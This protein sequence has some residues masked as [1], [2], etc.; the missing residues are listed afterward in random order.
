MSHK[1]TLC[2]LVLAATVS[3]CAT[4][5]QF[6]DQMQPAAMDTV[7]NRTRFDWNCPSATSTLISREVVQPALQGPLVNGI[8]RAEY[9]VGVDGCGQRQTI[10]VV[11]PQDGSGCFAGGPRE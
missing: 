9:T 8:P 4:Q 11:C 10:V 5:Q 1:L 7:L 2:M 6:L 3:G